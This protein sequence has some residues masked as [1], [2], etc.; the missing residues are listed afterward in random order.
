[1][2]AIEVPEV[3]YTEYSNRQ[4]VAIPLAVLVLALAIIGGGTWSRERRRISGWSSRAA[5]SSGSPT[6]AA[7]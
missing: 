5:W 7:T 1:M 6:T 4:L 2:V 3:N